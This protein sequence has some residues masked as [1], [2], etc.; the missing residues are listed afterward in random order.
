MG[1]A[2]DRW[3]GMGRD[4]TGWDGMGWDGMGRMAAG[5]IQINIFIREIHL[6]HLPSYRRRAR[7]LCP[8]VTFSATPEH[9]QREP[10]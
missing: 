5:E 3:D 8:A 10:A 6:L 9:P 4:G 2:W 7:A 1:G